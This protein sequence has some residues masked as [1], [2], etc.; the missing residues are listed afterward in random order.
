MEKLTAIPGK[1]A[2]YRGRVKRPII[3]VDQIDAPLT[4]SRVV[5]AQRLRFNA[6]FPIGTGHVELFEVRV[7]VEELVVRDSVVLDPDIGFIETIRKAADVRFPV[8]DKE[9]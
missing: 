3:E 8:A 2:N 9:V 7:A 4:R 5:E 6:K 1:A